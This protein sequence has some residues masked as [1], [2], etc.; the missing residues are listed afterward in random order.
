VDG[1]DGE[2]IVPAMPGG[3]E[4]E[5]TVAGSPKVFF[6]PTN[7]LPLQRSVLRLNFE[8]KPNASYVKMQC[9]LRR[10]IEQ[11]DQ[12]G[13]REKLSS[14]LEAEFKAA[15]QL[16][17]DRLRM[18]SRLAAAITNHKIEENK[19]VEGL[20]H[21]SYYT[22]VNDQRVIVTQP[23]GNF[24]VELKQCLTLDNA[25]SPEVILATE[26]AFYYPGPNDL[27]VLKFPYNYAKALAAFLKGN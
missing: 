18:A 12:T 8:I 3:L 20:E 21:R 6:L 27:I 23:Y 17:P 7:I 25:M 15:W 2:S 16:A 9:E 4:E 5:F 13:R 24:T 22:G 1:N 14:Q 11:K 10:L 26:W 19:R